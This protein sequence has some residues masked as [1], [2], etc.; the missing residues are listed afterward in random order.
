[1]TNFNQA[2]INRVIMRRVWYSYFL[3]LLSNTTAF[4]GFL[5]GAS[6][7]GFWQVAS[8]PNIIQNLLD[9]KLGAV[10]QY[11]IQS[12][13]H[14]Q[15]VALIALGVMVFSILSFGFKLRT[16]NIHLHNMRSV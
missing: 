16:P 14:G 13:L 15:T 7:V 9:V 5:F 3:S 12:L 2:K 1:M 8:V 4:Y 6:L 11:I 10:P